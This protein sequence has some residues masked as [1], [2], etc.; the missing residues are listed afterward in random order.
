MSTW[1]KFK[2]YTI[3]NMNLFI[4]NHVEFTN[5]KFQVTS[6]RRV[7]SLS[8]LIQLEFFHNRNF[9]RQEKNKKKMFCAFSLIDKTSKKCPTY[10][11]S[12]KC[13]SLHFG[14]VLN[15]HVCNVLDDQGQIGQPKKDPNIRRNLIR[16][17]G[18]AC[19]Y[20]LL[21]NT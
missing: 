5:L 6:N 19:R 20:L 18:R 11:K 2:F 7:T 10:F 3:E 17:T 14:G 12:L 8:L 13:F 9:T 21:V 4:K 16:I 1:S 15:Q